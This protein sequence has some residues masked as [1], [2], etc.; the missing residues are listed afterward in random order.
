MNPIL[1]IWQREQPPTQPTPATSGAR[2]GRSQAEL[3]LGDRPG[4]FGR[5]DIIGGR[6]LP[7]APADRQVENW[8]PAPRKVAGGPIA[9]RGRRRRR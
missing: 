6:V 1:P 7:G 4:P 8:V 3:L 9:L 5:G 2:R